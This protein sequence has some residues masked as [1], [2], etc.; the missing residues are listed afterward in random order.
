MEISQSPLLFPHIGEF[1]TGSTLSAGGIF[2]Q[3]HMASRL[4]I[5]AASIPI[6]KHHKLFP[7]DECETIGTSTFRAGALS[8][9]TG[10]HCG[11]LSVNRS[12]GRGMN[13]GTWLCEASTTS[14][15]WFLPQ[16]PHP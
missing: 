2:S 11:A 5:L 15:E 3:L 1:E 4:S 9:H 14:T 8:A 10:T 16:P 12:Q 7:P 6:L 13:P